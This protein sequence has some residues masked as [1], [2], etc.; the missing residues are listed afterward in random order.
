[1]R[2]VAQLFALLTGALEPLFA[3][4][5]AA[6]A[7]I[8]ATMCV[9][10]LLHPLARAGVR[11]EKARTRLAPEVAGLRKRYARDPERL[12]RALLEL[13]AREGVSPLAGIA[14]TL[15]QLPVFFVMYRLFTA[16]R[17]GGEPN[18][19]L[20][21]RLGPAPLGGRWAD[22]LADGGVLGAPGLVYLA[23]FGVLAAVALWS[24]RRAR[25]A[26]AP[27]PEQ[28]V[29]GMAGLVKVL[30]LL[31]FGTLVTA[32]FVPLAAGL[33]LATTTVWTA[34]ERALLH[35]GPAVARSGAAGRNR[36]RS[37]RK[38]G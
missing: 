3:T 36:R 35:R 29:P 11:G 30:P 10:T 13:H 26:V 37:G 21:D 12:R 15:L 18:G 14:P 24:Y 6:V 31:S 33:Y 8:V 9:R 28:A 4:S 5:A 17:V 25:A 19:L 2:T 32:A 1:M 20:A 16:P 23:L 27:A 34:V 7:I 22:A 38:E